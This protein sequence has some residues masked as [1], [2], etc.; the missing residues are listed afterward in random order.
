[1]MQVFRKRSQP[2][3]S[4]IVN[5]MLGFKDF[6]LLVNSSIKFMWS[7]VNVSVIHIMIPDHGWDGCGS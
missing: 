2:S 1:M 7:M 5:L 3:Y 4:C 6:M